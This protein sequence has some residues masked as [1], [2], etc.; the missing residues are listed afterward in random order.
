[1]M[2]KTLP[3]TSAESA[4]KTNDLVTA[5]IERGY[6]IPQG[7]IPELSIR[8]IGDGQLADSF[9]V[10]MNWP[11][12]ELGFPTS[13]VVKLPSSDVNSARIGGSIGAYRR[14]CDFYRQIAPQLT[15]RTPELL[16][17][18]ESSQGV[19]LEDLSERAARR[20][21]IG[22]DNIDFVRAG[23]RELVGLQ[24]PFWDDPTVASLPWLH[25][26]MGLPIPD[27]AERYRTSWKAVKSD[28]SDRF[29]PDEIEAVSRF[30]VACEDWAKSLKGPFTL[31]HH[32]YRFDN[33]MFEGTD[34][35]ILD[36][37]T[38]GWGLPMF[39]FAYLLGTSLTSSDRAAYE[40]ELVDEQSAAL[41]AAG[42]SGMGPDE[43]WEAYRLASF[44]TLL[45]LVPAARSV[46][47]SERGDQMFTTSIQRGARQIIELNALDLLG[48]W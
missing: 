22:A 37:Q 47:R 11:E 35:Y 28:W 39:D 21:Q 5:M 23:C 18:I 48:R 15:V 16:G 33:M 30:A 2:R 7:M 14:E 10:S 36:W 19:I 4:L 45:M 6:Q 40:R 9:L 29:Q 13:A 12:P 1:M 41:T 31:V 20:D 26:R 25:R 32:D 17:V 27:I 43:A 24:A 44:A 34:P 46:Q 3:A 8:P 42:V 38:V